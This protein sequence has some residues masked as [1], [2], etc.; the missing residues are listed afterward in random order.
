VAAKASENSIDFGLS[1]RQQEQH[2]LRTASSELAKRTISSSTM[3]HNEVDFSFKDANLNSA[4]N[5]VHF[6]DMCMDFLRKKCME[7]PEE[8]VIVGSKSQKSKVLKVVLVGFLVVQWILSHLFGNDLSVEVAEISSAD[9]SM[10]QQVGINLVVYRYQ[11][12]YCCCCC[13]CFCLRLQEV[14]ITV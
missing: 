6:K 4:I 2:R 5:R 10:G 12:L 13:L 11:D 3:A 9:V 8:N 14:Y 7:E 1:D